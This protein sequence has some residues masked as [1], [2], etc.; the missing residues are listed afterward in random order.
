MQRSKTTRKVQEKGK[1]KPA[2][3]KAEQA[4]VEELRDEMQSKE[5]DEKWEDT[6]AENGVNRIESKRQHKEKDKK[7]K[8][9]YKE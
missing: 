8:E 5:N 2:G 6:V 9:A 7:W 1:G 4:K 3:V